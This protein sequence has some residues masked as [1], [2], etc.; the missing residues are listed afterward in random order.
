M[1]SKKSEKLIIRLSKEEMELVKG[2]AERTGMSRAAVFR[3]GV[4][5][6]SKNRKPGK[7]PE[8]KEF[9]SEV[10]KGDVLNG[11]STA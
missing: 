5:I 2:I 1:K 11:R 4:N 8:L 9:F 3:L 10:S 7:V 6:I